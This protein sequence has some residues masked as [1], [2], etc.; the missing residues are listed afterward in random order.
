MK[1]TEINL[2][3]QFMTI[4]KGDFRDMDYV[5][6][7]YIFSNENFEK[8]YSIFDNHSRCLQPK[9]TTRSESRTT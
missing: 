4:I 6:K 3:N 1:L 8:D 7:T 5:E 2:E 9:R